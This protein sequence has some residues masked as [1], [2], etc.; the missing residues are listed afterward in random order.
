MKN[1]W[2]KPLS[3]VSTIVGLIGSLLI[4][5]DISYITLIAGIGLM[6]IAVL[7]LMPIL[8]YGPPNPDPIPGFGDGDYDE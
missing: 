2:C 8:F 6:W 1:D 3:F 4:T 7:G 5:S